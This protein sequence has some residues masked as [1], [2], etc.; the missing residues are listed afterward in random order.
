MTTLK[1]LI[2]IIIAEVFAATAIIFGFSLWA[3]NRLRIPDPWNKTA[4]TA[5][6]DS[7][8]TEGSQN[9]LVFYY[10]LQN[11]T[12]FDYELSDLSNVILM[13]DL[14]K[15]D[16]FAGQKNNKI[17]QPNYPV[18]I[19]AKQRLRFAVHL[20]YPYD[21]SL[22][23]DASADDRKKYRK[24]LEAYVNKHISSLNGFVLFDENHGYQI[25]L[26]KGW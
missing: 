4:I 10:T 20:R 21:K 19:P 8:G 2:V 11:N 18:M 13:A 9:Y 15:Q 22:N 5:I 14:K 6:Y 26:P 23:E 7:I 24:E 1:K 25:E 12:A 3:E 17:L 16:S